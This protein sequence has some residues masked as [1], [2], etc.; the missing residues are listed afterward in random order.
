[1]KVTIAQLV[2]ASEKNGWRWAKSSD[3]GISSQ[4]S[5]LSDPRCAT[6]SCVVG[7]GIANLK[8]NDH[9]GIY[10]FPMG[11]SSHETGIEDLDEAFEAIYAYNDK[12][13]TSYQDAVGFMK[14]TMDP[15][16][17]VEIEI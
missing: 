3:D 17:D 9:H 6:Y 5:Y 14:K 15:F 16:M 11:D 4:S 1:M 12:K 10:F 8:N 7:Q 13:A 2:K